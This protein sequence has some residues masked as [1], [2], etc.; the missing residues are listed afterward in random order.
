MVRMFRGGEGAVSHCQ[1]LTNPNPQ[2]D[3]AFRLA[4]LMMF[5][6][7][8]KD[9]FLHEGTVLVLE[10]LMS[11][12]EFRNASATSPLHLKKTTWIRVLGE[13]VKTRSTRCLPDA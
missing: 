4:W 2:N 1:F 13:Y 8:Y 12:G 9:L 5:F 3:P 11:R 7:C 6:A 10:L